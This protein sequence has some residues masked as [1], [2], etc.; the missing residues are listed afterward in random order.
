MRRSGPQECPPLVAQGGTF[1][2]RL[3][4]ETKRGRAMSQRHTGSAT[5]QG[6]SSPTPAWC[7]GSP[8]AHTAL[9]TGRLCLAPSPG[10]S[11]G[12]TDGSRS[13]LATAKHRYLARRK[14]HMSVL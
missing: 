9:H 10:H 7:T 4:G 2:S 8:T 5:V 6:C 3:R 1:E 11:H 14:P 13:S 12:W